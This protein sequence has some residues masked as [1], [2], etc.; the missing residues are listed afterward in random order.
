MLKCGMA[1][2]NSQRIGLVER[3]DEIRVLKDGWCRL[4]H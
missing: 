4:E 2:A 1:G 3:S